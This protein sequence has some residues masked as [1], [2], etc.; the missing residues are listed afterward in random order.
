[1]KRKRRERLA[2]MLKLHVVSAPLVRRFDWLT[3]GISLPRAVPDSRSLSLSLSSLSSFRPSLPSI[4]IETV[5]FPFLLSQTYTSPGRRPLRF[6][7]HSFDTYRITAT[8]SFPTSSHS[9]PAPGKRQ[10]RQSN[11]TT[12][13]TVCSTCDAPLSANIPLLHAAND[14]DRV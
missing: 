5:R 3:P 4:A 9:I 10:R 11:F 7:P 1:M 13:H 6:L 2:E 8:I 14:C 12:A